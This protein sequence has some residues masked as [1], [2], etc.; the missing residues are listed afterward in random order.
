MCEYLE[1]FKIMTELY[2]HFGL[3]LVLMTDPSV[4]CSELDLAFRKQLNLGTNYQTFEHFIQNEITENTFYLYQDELL[5]SYTFFRMPAD[6]KE[7]ESDFICPP[8]L[9]IGPMMFRSVT[10]DNILNNIKKL[11]I[12][13]QYQQDF[14]EFYNR[15]P[16][17]PSREL[18]IHT[19]MF[20][21]Q[22]FTSAPILFREI[23]ADKKSSASF[24]TENANY[25]M[26]SQPSV[27][28]T[29]IEARYHAE[30]ALME[31]VSTGN[32]KEAIQ[33]YHQ[34]I[35]YR[36]TPRSAS[37]LRDRKNILFTFNTLLRKA[38]EFG[39]V[40]PLHIDNLSRTL[41]IQIE[42][43]VTVEQLNQISDNMVRKYCILVQNY[44][45]RSYSELTQ[46]CM[47]QIEFYYNTD[48]SL[49]RLA[50]QCSV[51]PSYLSTVFH[52]ETGMTVT[53]YINKTRIR[54]SLILLNTTMLSIG[55]I[56]ARCGFG[57]ANYF[58]RIFR[59]LQGQSPKDY[60]QSIRK[61]S[62]EKA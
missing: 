2:H 59:K 44:A 57:D 16:I 14:V 19:M 45:R 60:R 10:S 23:S 40:H 35:S 29:T 33:R 58:S 39:G 36:L 18:W 47:N 9:C 61:K 4:Q 37:P 41:A 53:D 43:A 46:N 17:F 12:H 11:N 31:A 42:H 15:V 22:K 28:L 48:L 49:S 56:A 6:F 26:P 34:F 38:A 32:T 50:S 62:T 30:G 52:K 5:M 55:E 20:F 25:A 24:F 54:Q 1:A 7:S 21:F 51:S 13:P 3:N 8:V 27:A